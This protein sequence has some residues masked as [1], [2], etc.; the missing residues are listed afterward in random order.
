MKNELNKS[1]IA[2]KY[3]NLK[4]YYWLSI[5]LEWYNYFNKEDFD[6]IKNFYNRILKDLAKLENNFSTHAETYPYEYHR[7]RLRREA[8]YQKRTFLLHQ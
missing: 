2:W 7:Q 6:F 3:K 8:D 1:A 5:P 4:A